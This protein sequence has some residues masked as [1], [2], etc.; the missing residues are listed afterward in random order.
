V[1][2]RLVNGIQEN[3]AQLAKSPASA[4]IFLPGG[5]PPVIGS[6]F[7]QPDLAATLRRIADDGAAGFYSGRTAELLAKSMEESGG[8]ITA[9][10]LTAYQAKWR[11]P[12]E[13]EYRGYHI[14]GVGLPSS[15]G[16]V[17]AQLA[18]ILEGFEVKQMGWHS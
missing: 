5:K 12:I 16:V 9:A 3:Q 7:K 11:T 17:I 4:K 8:L 10:D 6:V 18:R 2:A 15:G 14:L 1:D 13:A